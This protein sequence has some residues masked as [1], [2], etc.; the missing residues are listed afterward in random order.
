MVFRA[1]FLVHVDTDDYLEVSLLI[2]EHVAT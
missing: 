2:L 1:E